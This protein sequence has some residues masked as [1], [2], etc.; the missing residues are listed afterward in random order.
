MNIEGIVNAV[1]QFLASPSSILKKEKIFVFLD[2]ITTI[3]LYNHLPR[4]IR[5]SQFLTDK[6]KSLAIHGIMVSIAAGLTSERLLNEIKQLCDEVID[7]G[8]V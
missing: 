2:S 7:I 6:L 4:T 8:H 3:L 1:D 5:F